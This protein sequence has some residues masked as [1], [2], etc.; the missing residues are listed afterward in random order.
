MGAQRNY[1][2]E[3]SHL[4][5]DFTKKKKKEEEGH[6]GVLKNKCQIAIL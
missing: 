4:G 3:I 6:L 5:Q 2:R 1:V